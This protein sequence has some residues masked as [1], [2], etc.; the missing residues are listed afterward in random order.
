L[1]VS[2][3]ALPALWSEFDTVQG[4]RRRYLPETLAQTHRSADVPADRVFWWGAWMVP[5]LKRQR[6]RTNSNA[7]E[8]PL[9]IYR[10]H[11]SPPRWPVSL[12]LDAAFRLEQ[13]SAIAGKL[14]TGTSL[15]SISRRPARREPPESRSRIADRAGR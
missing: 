5:I 11:V 10:R 7:G 13:P 12:A 2:V 1:V 9:E 14:K 3:P 4:H 6:A 8:S 15:W